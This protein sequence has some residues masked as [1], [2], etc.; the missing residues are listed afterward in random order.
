MLTLLNEQLCSSLVIYLDIRIAPVIYLFT[1]SSNKPRQ[2]PGSSNLT[3]P[4]ISM[5]NWLNNL[6]QFCNAEILQ[7]LCRRYSHVANEGKF[8][9]FLQREFILS[10]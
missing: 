4:W 9:D 5:C 6:K 1:A 7:H 8:I 2:D 3:D 10:G